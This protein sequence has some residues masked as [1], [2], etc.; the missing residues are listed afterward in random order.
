VREGCAVDSRWAL[1][2]LLALYGL[3]YARA[4]DHEFVWDDSSNVVE[5]A[6]FEAPLAEG[7]H[8]TQ[9]DFLDPSLL[10]SAKVPVPYESYRPLLFLSYAFDHA[11]FGRSARAMHGHGLVL[12]ALCILLAWRVC[13]L[14]LASREQALC[15]TALFALHPL[16][17]ETF[18]YVSARGDLL[19]AL[20]ALAATVAF[21]KAGAAPRL[22]IRVLWSAAASAAFALSLASK[23]AGAGLPVALGL[24]A[25]ALGRLRASLAPLAGLASA[26]VLYAGARRSLVGA[27]LSSLDPGSTLQALWTLPHFGFEYLRIFFVPSDLSI[28]R[29]PGPRPAVALG[30]LALAGGCVA[31]GLA[32]RNRLGGWSDAVRRSTAGL[33]WFFVLL[34]PSAVA[35]E[36]MGVVADRYAALPILGVCLAVVVLASRVWSQLRSR[37][38]LLPAAA[39]TWVLALL[40]VTALQVP[41]WRSNQSLYANSLLVE[42]ESSMAHYRMGVLR[43]NEFDWGEAAGFFERAAA[44]DGENVRALNNLGVAYLHLGRLQEADRALGGALAISGE[45]NFRAWNNLAKLRFSQQRPAAGCAALGRSLSIN[46]EYEVARRNYARICSRPREANR[47]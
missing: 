18:C 7:L 29:L 17:T 1:V 6:H 34:A 31:A 19:A 30:W 20:L 23:E 47:G 33:A 38:A 15:A 45:I 36:T 8:A 9:H 22:R 25:L 32:L 46:P 4:L 12:G 26:L 39:G 40:A 2:A 42:P 28:E 44:L 41:V 10:R 35:A 5:D 13:A 24:L 11:L 21:L 14:V 27:E 16:Q 43:A 3:V 37:R